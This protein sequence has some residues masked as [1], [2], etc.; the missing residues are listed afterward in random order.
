MMVLAL[1]LV[2]DVCPPVIRPVCDALEREDNAAAADLAAALALDP[3][4]PP[5]HRQFGAKIASGV[6]VEVEAT[7]ASRCKALELLQA[8][9]AVPENPRPAVLERRF[10]G[11]AGA[12]D[13]KTPPASPKPP[14]SPPKPS[15]VSPKLP[16]PPKSLPASP[17]PPESPP[18][19]PSAEAPKCGSNCGRPHASDEYFALAAKHHDLE[20]VIAVGPQTPPARPSRTRVPPRKPVRPQLVVGSTLVGVGGAL[21]GVLVG[22]LV[23]F[24]DHEHEGR[25]LIREAPGRGWTLQEQQE[26]LQVYGKAEQAQHAAIGTG[27]GAA[28]TLAV[29]AALLGTLH[30]HKKSPARA[31]ARVAGGGLVFSV[32]F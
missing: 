16:E 25:Q 32:R 3:A 14:E 5:V 6:W 26:F 8:Y 9:R 12:C 24:A 4:V 27:V 20:V 2:L 31:A 15:S 22:S 30:K 17:K 10:A 1:V 7:P 18:K 13:E 28:V 19:S 23:M 21:L 29:G 11:L